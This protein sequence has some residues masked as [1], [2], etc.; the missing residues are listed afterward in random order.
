MK[1]TVRG[2]LGASSA[3]TACDNRAD[4]ARAELNVVEERNKWK[5]DMLEKYK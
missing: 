2:G 1:S 3:R 5:K 4:T